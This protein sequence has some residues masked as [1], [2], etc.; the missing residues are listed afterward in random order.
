MKGGFKLQDRQQQQ[1]ENPQ[2]APQPCHICKKVIAGSYGQSWLGGKVV[3][4]CSSK[5]EVKV[6]QLQQE[7]RNEFFIKNIC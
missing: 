5:C 3:W 2:V 4:S 7:E 6:H 1:K